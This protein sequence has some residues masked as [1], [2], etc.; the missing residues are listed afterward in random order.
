MS[1]QCTFK[2]PKKNLYFSI[3]GVPN[4]LLEEH[5]QDDDGELM[6]VYEFDN[7]A[8]MECIENMDDLETR[9]SIVDLKK[10]DAEDITM[11]DI[12][13]TGSDRT[14]NQNALYKSDKN[15]NFNG[16]HSDKVPIS[17]VSHDRTEF[18]PSKCIDEWVYNYVKIIE[19]DT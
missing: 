3:Y 10:G 11:G 9:L 14:S 17:R 12:R 15:S 19:N 2:F 13:E 5:A 1:S 18:L 6:E 4:V 16:V 7:N 8:L